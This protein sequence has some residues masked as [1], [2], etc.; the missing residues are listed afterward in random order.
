MDKEKLTN[1]PGYLMWL[2]VTLSRATVA[3]GYKKAGPTPKG[4]LTE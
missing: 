3:Q 4:Q 2:A 1:Y